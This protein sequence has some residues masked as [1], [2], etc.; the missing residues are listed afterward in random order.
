MKLSVLLIGFLFFTVGCGSQQRSDKKATKTMKVSEKSLIKVN[1]YLV[2]S[3]EEDIDNYIRRHGLK[4]KR[5]GSGLRY[6]IIKQGS[7]PKAK[8]GEIAVINYTIRLITGDVVYSSA[9]S[10]P[11][12]FE[13]GHGGVESGLEEGILLLK[14]GD[15]A[16]F[17]LP[18]HLAFGLHG[19]EKKIPPVMPLVYDLELLNLK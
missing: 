8:L 4:M 9:K 10:G 6:M 17:I 2:H 13:I 18:S 12:T 19:D 5:T 11:K 14:K 16:K 3:E 15:Q 7:G 1:R